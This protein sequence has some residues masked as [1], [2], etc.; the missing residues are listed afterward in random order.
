MR[1][2]RCQGHSVKALYMTGF[3]GFKLFHNASNKK[4]VPKWYTFQFYF[5]PLHPDTKIYDYG[6]SNRKRL[7]GQPGQVLRIS[8][9]G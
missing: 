2:V 7:Q 4:S 5:V 8:P 6:S 9:K 3:Q 1:G